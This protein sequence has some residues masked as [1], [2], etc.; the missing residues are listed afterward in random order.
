[1]L[2]VMVLR[3][4]NLVDSAGGKKTLLPHPPSPS[5]S[6]RNPPLPR[7]LPMAPTIGLLHAGLV[8]DRHHEGIPL[9]ASFEQRETAIGLQLPLPQALLAVCILLLQHWTFWGYD[10]VFADVVVGPLDDLEDMPLDVVLA[11]KAL[12][13][14]RT[15]GFLG[16]V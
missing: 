14:V 12:F 5:P 8:P 3:R 11:G 10:D 2:F 9:V 6:W 16:G 7:L 13:A 1:M 15:G 4:T